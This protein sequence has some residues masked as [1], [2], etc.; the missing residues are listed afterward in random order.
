[1]VVPPSCKERC[2]GWGSC[3]V[4]STPVEE[5]V[6]TLVA[7]VGAAV[8]GEVHR[9]VR[10]RCAQGGPCQAQCVADAS[11]VKGTAPCGSLHFRRGKRARPSQGPGSAR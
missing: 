9:S 4:L 6:K 10:V 1:M 8:A 11:A 7:M 2:R 5:R 3:A